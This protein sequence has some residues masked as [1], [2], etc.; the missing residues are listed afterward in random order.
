M[1][2]GDR[3]A[4]AAEQT[5]RRNRLTGSDHITAAHQG[6]HRLV[7][8]AQP[9]VLDHD[10]PASC[11]RAR[12]R[13]LA[14]GH[15]EHLLTDGTGK[16]DPAMAASVRVLGCVERRHDR[17]WRLQ[18]PHPATT[19]L[20]STGGRGSCRQSGRQGG[21]NGRQQAHDHQ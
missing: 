3:Q 6:C 4:V 12:E 7:R 17:W 16:I 8:G 21:E 11:H 20:W 19:R 15:G 10:D 18:R 14:R 13:D 1:Q 2:A 5:E 9:A